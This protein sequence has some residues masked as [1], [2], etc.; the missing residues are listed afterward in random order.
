LIKN[1]HFGHVKITLWRH[2]SSQF[3]QRVRASYKMVSCG[4][5]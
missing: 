1:S 3:V 5:L 2:K 4:Y